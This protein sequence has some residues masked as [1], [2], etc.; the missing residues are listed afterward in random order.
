MANIVSVVIVAIQWKQS[1]EWCPNLIRNYFTWFVGYQPKFDGADEHCR[2]HEIVR[3]TILANVQCCVRWARS[4]A[5]SDGLDYARKT[6]IIQTQIGID[7][8]IDKCLSCY[9][10]RAHP[11]IRFRTWRRR[12]MHEHLARLFCV[13]NGS[14]FG[15]IADAKKSRERIREN[16]ACST[17]KEDAIQNGRRW[18]G[19]KNDNLSDSTEKAT[20]WKRER[21]WMEKREASNV[22]FVGHSECPAICIYMHRTTKYLQATNFDRL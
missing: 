4:H 18:W 9:C 6:T 12:L 1:N 8:Q 7:I 19:Y 15:H 16:E 20:E 13:K 17:E 21:H 10:T 22:S 14:N 2:A 3:F 5:G 11:F